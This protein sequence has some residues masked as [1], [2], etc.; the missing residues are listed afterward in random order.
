[1]SCFFG[2]PLTGPWLA[3]RACDNAGMVAQLVTPPTVAPTAAWTPS[4]TVLF[5]V[6]RV[7]ASRVGY[8]TL[9]G[10]HGAFDYAHFQAELNKLRLPGQVFQFA[11]QDVNLDDEPA[12]AMAFWTSL[13]L[14]RAPGGNRTEGAQAHG[15]GQLRLYLDAEHLQHQLSTEEVPSATG[16][17]ASGTASAGAAGASVRR[18]PVFIFTVPLDEPVLIDWD[19]QVRVGVGAS[20]EREGAGASK[21]REGGWCE[22]GKRGGWCE[23][24]KRGGWGAV[25]RRMQARGVRADFSGP[26]VCLIQ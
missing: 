6:Y 26:L 4:R 19:R 2:M 25:L 21:E 23:Q 16:S 17:T 13:H 3:R 12:M 11:V 20:E 7:A 14:G 10:E 1:M 8:A 24:G 18:V 15:S 9:G 22:Q 5:Q